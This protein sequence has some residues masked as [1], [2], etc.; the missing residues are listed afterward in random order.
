MSCMFSENTRSDKVYLTIVCLCEQVV[1]VWQPLFCSE[2]CWS[3]CSWFSL[4]PPFS[5]L[6]APTV[7]QVSS[8]GG[9]RPTYSNQMR[10]LSWYHRRPLQLGNPDMWGGSGPQ[11]TQRPALPPSPPLP[12]STMC[13]EGW[14]PMEEA[15]ASLLA[16][17][18]WQAQA[19]ALTVNW[20]ACVGLSLLCSVA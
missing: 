17:A 8:T 15:W 1:R 14:G 18:K 13:R 12:Q 16:G 3:A 10:R 6:N 11:Q 2:L 7:S 5:T 19:R 4:L 20:W 9:I